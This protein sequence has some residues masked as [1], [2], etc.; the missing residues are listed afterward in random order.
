MLSQCPGTELAGELVQ[1]ERGVESGGGI[2]ET[3]RLRRGDFATRAD[4]RLQLEEHR[5]E[6]D[7]VAAIL[8]RAAGV[9]GE[10]VRASYRFRRSDDDRSR[11]IEERAVT[12]SAA[13]IHGIHVVDRFVDDNDIVRSSAR[14]LDSLC[15]GAREGDDVAMLLENALEG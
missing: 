1:A 13:D 10:T 11:V 8:P 9:G 7:R 4:K 5:L 2:H 12:E 6:I 14:E 3:L 15:R